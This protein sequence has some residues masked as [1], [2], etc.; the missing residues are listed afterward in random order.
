MPA[1]GTRPPPGVALGALV[2]TLAACGAPGPAAPGEPSASPGDGGPEVQER[3]APSRSDLTLCALRDGPERE[4]PQTVFVAAWY[5]GRSG[6]DPCP[7]ELSCQPC[8]K[9]LR[10]SDT[11]DAP[12]NDVFLLHSF[13]DDGDLVEGQAYTLQLELRERYR[14][15]IGAREND[16]LYFD[17]VP[18]VRILAIE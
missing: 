11:P 18:D 3:G 16:P 13:T 5:R 2:A 1:K 7:P 6:C 9:M 17:G 10:F 14:E 15:Q 4:T 12:E 8:A